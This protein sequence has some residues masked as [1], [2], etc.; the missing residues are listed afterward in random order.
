[1][2]PLA[3]RKRLTRLAP[4]QFEPLERGAEAQFQGCSL[5][6]EDPSPPR[7]KFDDYSH[8]TFSFSVTFHEDFFSV[9]LSFTLNVDPPTFGWPV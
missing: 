7:A 4:S 8:F 9:K 3:F 6:S 2:K 5:S 1:L